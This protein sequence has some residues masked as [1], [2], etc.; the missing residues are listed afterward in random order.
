MST[1]FERNLINENTVYRVA[2]EDLRDGDTYLHHHKFDDE[3]AAES[4]IESLCI[5]EDKENFGEEFVLRDEYDYTEADIY[6]NL[7]VVLDSW[8]D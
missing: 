3:A 2:E 1:L 7:K 4:Y 8:S 5:E 6:S